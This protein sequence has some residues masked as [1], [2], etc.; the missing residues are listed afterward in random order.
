M[1]KITKTAVTICI[2]AATFSFISCNL[3]ATLDG[4]VL[5][6]GKPQARVVPPGWEV[7]DEG[8]IAAAQEAT[9]KPGFSRVFPY[10]GALT[11]L[12]NIGL[13]K[14][15]KEV[16][17]DAGAAFLEF[18]DSVLHNCLKFADGMLNNYTFGVYETVTGILFPNKVTPDP[19]IVKLQESID[20]IQD[21]IEG[22]K[23][24]LANLSDDLKYEFDGQKISNRIKEIERERTAFEKMFSY[25][26][27]A[28]EGED[29]NSIDLMTYY[30]LKNHAV[31][32]F[33]SVD[34]MRQ[35]I[36]NFFTD[37]Y[38]GDAVATRTYGESYRLIGEELFAWRYQTADFMETLIAQELEIATKLYSLAGLMLDPTDNPNMTLDLQ[39]QEI[40]KNSVDSERLEKLVKM[41]TTAG[42]CQN[43]AV[44]EE[45]MQIL[46]NYWNVQDEKSYEIRQKLLAREREVAEGVWNKLADAFGE[47]E[48]TI[49]AIQI[50]VDKEGEITCNIRGVRCTFKQNVEAFKYAE[51]LAALA[52]LSVSKKTEAAWLKIYTTG[53]LPSENAD[54]YVRMLT[55]DD[56]G[57]ILEFYTKR[58]LVVTDSTLCN[59]LSED[60]T[61][62][63]RCKN[64]EGTVQEVT[65]FN[66]F[67]YDAGFD[68]QGFADDTKFACRNSKEA[69]G[70]IVNNER[71]DYGM[72]LSWLDPSWNFVKC[73]D[74]LHFWNVKVSSVCGNTSTLKASDDLL[75][76]DMAARKSD[77]AVINR[78][79]YYNDSKA[80][81]AAYLVPNVVATF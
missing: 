41:N 22:V 32:A 79:K 14:A 75:L 74:G 80:S 53:C 12:Y 38:K 27:I 46:D 78:I 21:S 18:S 47:Y 54:G 68:F 55:K 37:Y 63:G 70:F 6:S 64:P 69:M 67:K 58:G 15:A 59:L 52:E 19:Q 28:N 23:F 3:N 44:Y 9:E 61:I 43:G 76:E 50:P 81:Y 39:I 5:T 13:K 62:K 42:T 4:E 30:A 51:K 65:L 31:E 8:E 20:Q 34:K 56:Y 26:Q 77:K 72:E 2:I 29:K 71:Q 36:Q 35:A 60:G 57:R 40:M 25:L 66:I 16:E 11:K 48:S 1:N 17:S 7:F 24:L 49:E 73:F 10:D 45:I 33:G